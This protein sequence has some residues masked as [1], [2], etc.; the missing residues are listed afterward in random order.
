MKFDG[1]K[2]YEKVENLPYSK[3]SK[4]C[5]PI[6]NLSYFYFSLI[7]SGLRLNLFVDK[8]LKN[9]TFLVFA[10]TTNVN[11]KKNLWSWFK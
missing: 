3:N 2:L 8:C 5:E 7:N 1:A 4:I 11:A 10:S 9:G 6:I